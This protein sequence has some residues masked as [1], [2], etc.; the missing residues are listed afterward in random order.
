[1]LDFL[2]MYI[3]I[4]TIFIAIAFPF[5]LGVIRLMDGLRSNVKLKTLLQIT[6]TPFSIEYLRWQGSKTPLKKLY[7]RWLNIGFILSVLTLIYLLVSAR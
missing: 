2:I 7:Y 5:V 1:M 6:L 3:V 4:I